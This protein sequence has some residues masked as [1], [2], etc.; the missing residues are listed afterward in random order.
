MANNSVLVDEANTAL[1][2]VNPLVVKI[3]IALLIFFIGFIIGKIVEKIILRFFKI[4]DLD[5]LFR[6]Q[7]GLKMSLSIVISTIISY[8]IYVV[9][10]V[11]ALNRLEIATT[12]ITTIVILLV[13]VLLLFVIF[14]LN[15]VFANMN[16]GLIIKFRGNLKVGDYIRIKNK[17]V[18]GHIVN[19]NAL[20]IRL[21]TKKDEIVFIPNMALFKSEIV[22]PKKIPKHMMHHKH[23]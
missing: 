14:G 19:M 16:A 12:I 20:N 17:N 21:E 13:V 15:D 11:M 6:Q 4:S 3:V 1:S 7:T 8:F 9:A 10:V 18:E 2:I 22:K 5:K 23:K